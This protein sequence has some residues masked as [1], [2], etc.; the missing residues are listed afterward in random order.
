MDFHT[1]FH[2]A[3]TYI[4]VLLLWGLVIGMYLDVRKRIGTLPSH[5]DGIQE[6]ASDEEAN[7]SGDER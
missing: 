2:I 6:I 4:P 1:A 7:D 3:G 5:T